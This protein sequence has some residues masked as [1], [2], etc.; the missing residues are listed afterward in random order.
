MNEII[1][2][3]IAPSTPSWSPMPFAAVARLVGI[4]AHRVTAICSRYVTWP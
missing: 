2:S 3:A 4:S 1:N